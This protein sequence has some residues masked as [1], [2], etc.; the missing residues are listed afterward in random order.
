MG[1][2]P[3]RQQLILGDLPAIFGYPLDKVRSIFF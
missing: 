1:F 2:Q 3:M